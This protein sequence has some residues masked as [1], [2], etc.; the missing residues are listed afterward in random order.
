MKNKKRN[1]SS[2]EK[3]TKIKEGVKHQ[4]QKD[5]SKSQ[6]KKSKICTIVSEVLQK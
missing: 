6:A 3:E 5:R 2:L 1:N 4:R